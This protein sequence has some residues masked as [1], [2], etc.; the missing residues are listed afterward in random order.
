MEIPDIYY[1]TKLRQL[2]NEAHDALSEVEGLDTAGGLVSAC[3][4]ANQQLHTLRDQ[5]RG[6]LLTQTNK[7]ASMRHDVDDARLEAEVACAERDEAWAT[8]NRLKQLVA[9]LQAPAQ[10]PTQVIPANPQQCE[11]TS[12][13]KCASVGPGSVAVVNRS[14]LPEHIHFICPRCNADGVRTARSCLI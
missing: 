11:G 3:K 13:P 10:V 5:Q 4:M 12:T 7:I 6:Q 8:V 14:S 9:E 2:I 1:I